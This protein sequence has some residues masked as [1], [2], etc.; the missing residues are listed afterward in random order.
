MHIPPIPTEER[1]DGKG[2][3]SIGESAAETTFTFVWH[4]NGMYFLVPEF[5]GLPKRLTLSG[6][7]DDGRPVRCDSL[8]AR[9]SCVSGSAEGGTNAG[10]TGS[11]L[12]A[13]RP[14][15]LGTRLDRAPT[16]A[17]CPLL[18]HHEGIA[19][20]EDDGWLIELVCED[21]DAVR[22][23]GRTSAL[24][25][26]PTEGLLLKLSRPD[27]SAQDYEDKARQITTLLSLADGTGVTWHRYYLSWNEGESLE[28]LGRWTGDEIGPGEGVPSFCIQPFLEQCL[29]TWRS[30][31][32]EK[33]GLAK[34]AI[35]YINLSNEGY[36]DSRLLSIAQA[37]E[38]LA[39][40]WVPTPEPS[41]PVKELRSKL[42]E[43][44]K[45]WRTRCPGAD[46]D[47]QIADRVARSITDS[48]ILA[49]MEALADLRI[50]LDTVGLDLRELKRARDH[51]A[52]CG[53]LPDDLLEDKPAALRLLQG[54]Q[55]GLQLILLSEL[56][57]SNR[58]VAGTPKGWKA[59][60]RLIQD[61]LRADDS[62][63][64]T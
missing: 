58:V 49:R 55:F 43:A 38:M 17:V 57:Y 64:M 42:L 54:A 48:P 31:S 5:L 3:F 61:F 20:V 14:V 62:R 59:Y 13:N 7:L 60:D 21:R 19:E 36:L 41:E 40:E 8:F 4:H 23:A 50:S 29:P 24:W 27:A 52:H 37:W 56:G 35:D 63:E 1:F 9:E 44:C 25:H 10:P 15:E 30:W 28:I 2:V 53:V 39:N 46:P 33:Q 6:I 12:F 51:V 34:L 47:A 26:V 16:E 45:D 18:G 22:E 32:P 11:I